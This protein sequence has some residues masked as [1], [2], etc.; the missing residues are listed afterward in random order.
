M[1]KYKIGVKINNN[2]CDGSIT[3]HAINSKEAERIAL[4]KV[5]RYFFEMPGNL[6]STV[7]VKSIGLAE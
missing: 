3:V 1:S 6:V 4:R 5:I 7:S 2:W